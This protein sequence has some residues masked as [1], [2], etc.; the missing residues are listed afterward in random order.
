LRVAWIF[1]AQKRAVIYIE[2]DGFSFKGNDW[3]PVCPISDLLYNKEV[4]C[5]RMPLFLMPLAG[6]R[7]YV[8]WESIGI[9]SMVEV[10]NVE[11]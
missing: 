6:M 3:A 5:R 2:I 7:L 8:K 4:N 10:Q 1:H 11:G 9:N